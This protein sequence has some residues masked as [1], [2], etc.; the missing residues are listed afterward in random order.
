MPQD[1]RAGVGPDKI[2]QA[3]T[4]VGV[5][6]SGS[7]RLTPLAVTVPML[8]TV[9]SKPMLLPAMTGPTGSAVLVT[10]TS[11][12]MTA[13]DSAGAPQAA[14]GTAVLLPSPRWLGAQCSVPATAG[15]YAGGVYGP[16]A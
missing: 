1:V 4:P 15:V 7:L 8:L 6:G 13:L 5:V 9:M 16:D 3:P 14:S 2:V 10:W 11:G 12:W